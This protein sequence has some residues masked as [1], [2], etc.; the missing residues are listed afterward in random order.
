MGSSAYLCPTAAA[1]CLRRLFLVWV[2]SSAMLAL[3]LPVVWRCLV[4]GRSSVAGSMLS[5]SMRL[6]ASTFM[7]K[8]GLLLFIC[9][10]CD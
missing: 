1:S 5:G 3:G 8:Y 10:A 4:V 9:A 2:R 7:S 6:G